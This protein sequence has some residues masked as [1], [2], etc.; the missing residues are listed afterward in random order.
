MISV[1]FYFQVHQPYRLKQSYS[2]FDIGQNHF[3]EDEE[4]NRQ[5]CNKVAAKC[6]L[7]TNKLMLE[8]IEKLK[9]KFKVSYSL[10]GVA[11][12]QF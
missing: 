11:I 2:F 3:Y 7:P 4:T 10:T 9:G 1:C 12:E 6:Y 8:I 5:V